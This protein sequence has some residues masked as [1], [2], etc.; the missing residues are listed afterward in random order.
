MTWRRKK[1]ADGAEEWD[2]NVCWGSSDQLA[3]FDE[4]VRLLDQ[5]SV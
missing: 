5:T 3:E 4:D 2:N 1:E